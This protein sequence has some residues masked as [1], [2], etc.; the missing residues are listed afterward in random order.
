MATK[1]R[2]QADPGYIKPAGKKKKLNKK[3]IAL[4]AIIL[5]LAGGGGWYAYQ[6]LFQPQMGDTLPIF[7][8]ELLDS[9]HTVDIL[10]MGMDARGSET[11][12]RTD[13]IMLL[14]LHTG[15][16]KAALISIPRDTLVKNPRGHNTKVNGLNATD[17]PEAACRAVSELLRVNVDHYVLLNFD[18]FAAIIDILGGIDMNVP[19]AMYHWDPVDPELQIDIKAGQQHMDGQTALNYVRFRG[20]PSADIGRVQRQ[21]E[22]LKT[23][24]AE[25]MQTKTIKKLPAMVTEMYEYVATDMTVKEM[26]SLANLARDFS[27]EDI[28]SATLPGSNYYTDA[29]GSCW[30][31]DADI[32]PRL[33]EALLAGESV[34]TW[35]DAPSSYSYSTGV[36]SS[37]NA[38]A[39]TEEVTEFYIDV[40]RLDD[41][42][43]EDEDIAG[44]SGESGGGAEGAAKPEDAAP[45]AGNADGDEP[46]T[47]DAAAPVEEPVEDPRP[48]TPP[49]DAEEADPPDYGGLP[50]PLE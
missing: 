21:Q 37:D 5:L 7:D 22:F 17:G 2:N 35:S 50:A 25:L 33:I 30:K 39:P 3:G 24:Y 28:V 26:A 47:A 43:D 11:V 1:K 41:E 40:P 12:G 19:A 45:A 48:A 27:P 32:A 29:V 23:L 38:T 36:P 18:G 6:Q 42:D 31:A 49:P 46:S 34:E 15:E 14:S 44:E 4:L 9:D 16:K 10:L 20:T 8:E 13:T